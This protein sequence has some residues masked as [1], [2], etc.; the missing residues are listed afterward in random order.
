MPDNDRARNLSQYQLLGLM[1]QFLVGMVFYMVG[2][3]SRTT[4]SAHTGS[5]LVLSAHALLTVGLAAGAAWIIRA[6]VGTPDWR[7]WLARGGA[8]AIAVAAAA[9]LLTLV[10]HS[11]WW[12]FVMAVGFTAA[13]LAYAGLLIPATEDSSPALNGTRPPKSRF[14]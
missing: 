2:I 6:T 9:G 1:L 8:I 5:I 4:G 14:L 3:P 13:L 10:T 11:G 7:S 12:S